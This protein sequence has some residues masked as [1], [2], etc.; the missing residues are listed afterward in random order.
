MPY[1]CQRLKASV[2]PI[3]TDHGYPQ[4][5]SETVQALLSNSLVELHVVEIWIKYNSSLRLP[6]FQACSDVSSFFSPRE[7]KVNGANLEQSLQLAAQ[8]V[9]KAKP[10]PAK[11]KKRKKENRRKETQQSLLM[12]TSLVNESCMLL[13]AEIVLRWWCFFMLFISWSFNCH[14]NRLQCKTVCNADWDLA[15]VLPHCVRVLTM[16]WT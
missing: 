11:R 7:S 14:T 16:W 13:N 1:T 6:A 8:D 9:W 10:L 2:H 12:K 4:N 5:F 3:Y 15:L